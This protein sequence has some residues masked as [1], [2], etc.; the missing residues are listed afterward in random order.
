VLPLPVLLRII[1]DVCAGLHCAHELQDPRGQSLNVVHRD[2]SPQNILVTDT[3]AVKVIDFGVVKARVRV[4]EDTNPGVVKGKLPYMAPERALG[5][6]VDRRADIWAIGAVMYRILAGRAA[7][8]S[9]G[10]PALIWALVLR[11]QLGSL[12]SSVPPRIARIVLKALARDPKD[13]YATAAELQAALEEALHRLSFE[14][15]TTGEDVAAFVRAVLGSALAVRRAAIERALGSE[16]QTATLVFLRPL[17]ALVPSGGKDIPSNPPQIPTSQRI[18]LPPLR[19]LPVPRPARLQKRASTL[20]AFAAPTPFAL[21]LSQ[22]AS[23]LLLRLP[24]RVR[25]W[26]MLVAACGLGALVFALHSRTGSVAAAKTSRTAAAAHAGPALQL[27]SPASRAQGPEPTAVNVNDLALESVDVSALPERMSSSA[28]WKDAFA[29]RQP[30]M[31]SL[32]PAQVHAL[33]VLHSSPRAPA[34]LSD[35]AS[36]AASSSKL[37][38]KLAHSRNKPEPSVAP[39]KIPDAPAVV[40]QSAASSGLTSATCNPPFALD[41]NGRKKFRPECF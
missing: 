18:T 21:R 26:P 28:L 37:E 12:P 5:A 30:A 8:D 9:D 16:E 3:G 39:A 32:A 17:M 31:S 20:T 19:K 13:R 1:V 25:N 33:P 36:T 35:A 22:R 10:N 24:P 14:T 15:P 11:N 38:P 40:E 23:A 27:R 2:V 7:Y 6:A 34:A 41:R 4:T 29:S